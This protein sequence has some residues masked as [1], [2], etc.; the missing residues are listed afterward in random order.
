MKYSAI[1]ARSSLGKERQGDTVEHQI[2]MIKEYA[3]RSNI[4]AN[5]DDRYIYEED[6]ESGYKTTLLQRPSMQRLIN[7][8]ENGLIGIV[9][10]KGI[11]R[12]ARD[13]GET[14]TT[15]KRLNNKGV[16]VISIEENYDSFRDD[17]TMF[18]IYAVMAEQES[19]KTAIRVSLGNKQKA[20][21]GLWTSS[22]TPLG[23]TKVKNIIDQ[24]L[25]NKIITEGKNPQS[26][27]P[28]ENSHIVKKIF[29]MYAYENLGR[30]RIVNRLNEN[31]YR[32][33]KGNVF[34]EKYVKDVLENP[35][36]TG[37]IVYGKT[38]YVFI[39]D[40]L[41]NRKIQQTHR[42]DEKDWAIKE[43]AHPAIITQELFDIVQTKI[44]E[45]ETKFNQGRKF[46]AA[47]H[48]LTG[49][50]KCGKCGGIMICQKRTNKKKNGEKKE[51]R[52]YVCSTYHRKGRHICDQ[53]NINA[54]NLEQSVAEVI[55]NKIKDALQTYG[56]V[57]IDKVETMSNKENNIKSEIKSIET[58]LQKKMK[59]LRT[60]LETQDI[61]DEE[62]FSEI[63]L[64]LQGE[65]KSLR[66]NKERLENQISTSTEENTVDKLQR[67]KDKFE[68]TNFKSLSDARELFHMCVREIIILNSEV[69]ELKLTFL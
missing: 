31:G 63:N 39:E 3:K 61:Y 56:N 5:F 68:E 49:L 69:E 16:R 46:N 66:A 12:F 45:N 8:I 41:Q 52:Y 13:S 42:V 33:P 47:K 15:A 53:A 4:D 51:Y 27:Y 44:K 6:G 23:Y 40:E 37:R 36:Y 14:I 21:N 55:D 17:P 2:E 26:L 34:S 20:R 67:L 57:L 54:D 59:A 38:R 7:D 1:Y 32:T 9:F 28:D 24:E 18:Q 62:T 19:R 60:L 43:N 10:F 50:I 65:I 48:P 29:E 35:V 30:K 25:K 58:M 64:E 22:V 11:S